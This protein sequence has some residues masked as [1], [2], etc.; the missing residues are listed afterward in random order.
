[1]ATS[2]ASVLA[3][4]RLGIGAYYHGDLLRAVEVLEESLAR[5]RLTGDRV[6]THVALYELGEALSYRREYGR[7]R[8]LHEEGLALKRELGDRWHVAFSIFGLGLLDF[9]EGRLDDA[10]ARGR[11]CLL[12][13]RELDDRWGV[14]MCLEFLGWVEA[15]RGAMPR[16]VRLLA[17]ADG[18]RNR[19]G[20]TLIAP[21]QDN[22]NH[23]VQAT[24]ASLGDL[25]FDSE[26]KAGESLDP[27]ASVRLALED[28]TAGSS[29]RPPTG[30]LTPRE[31]QIANLVA[32]GLS[33]KEI[34]RKLS[35]AERTADPHVEHIL[36]K[37]GLH[38]RLQIA[39]W[40]DRQGAEAK[41]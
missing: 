24:R 14:A 6:G 19:M 9:L 11:E 8:Q 31:L 15:A 38:S 3:L 32:S 29:G 35:I 39:R 23:A 5:Y 4:L 36:N 37:L 25:A 30:V 28:A 2:P 18:G 27:E 12:M 13:R 1:L 41:R 17:A 21:H 7:A 16:A 40:A 33:N 10:A 26:W 20:A 22:H 34:A